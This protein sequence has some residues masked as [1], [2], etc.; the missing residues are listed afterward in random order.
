MSDR[1][2]R[3]CPE[4]EEERDPALERIQE[5]RKPGEM[6]TAMA[7]GSDEGEISVTERFEGE[8][9]REEALEALA[10]DD[11]EEKFEPTRPD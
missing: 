3:E 1:A 7:S 4:R 2:D 5:D 6:E 8:L 11:E 9:T 10:P